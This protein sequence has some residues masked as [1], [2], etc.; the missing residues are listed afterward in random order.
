MKKVLLSVMM[1]VC[2]TTIP[3]FL[4]LSNSIF[5]AE[6]HA[7]NRG[8]YSKTNQSVTIY[9]ESGACKG[10]FA[11]YLHQSKRYIDFKN[12]W[13]CIQGKTRFAHSGN[14]YVIK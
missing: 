9:H 1:L 12:T 8:E 10:T 6:A 14:W 7:P 5:T 3:S 4:T 2:L 13:V 11:V